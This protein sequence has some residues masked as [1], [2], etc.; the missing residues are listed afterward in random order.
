LHDPL[1]LTVLDTALLFIVFI[2]VA[3]MRMALGITGFYLVAMNGDS[4]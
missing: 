1:L 2:A 3:L 4:I